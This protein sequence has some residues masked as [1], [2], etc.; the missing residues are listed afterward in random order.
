MIEGVVRGVS[1][2]SN[3][4]S[5]AVRLLSMICPRAC[6]SV[7]RPGFHLSHHTGKLVA[8]QQMR[9]VSNVTNLSKVT[10]SVKSAKSNTSVAVVNSVSYGTGVRSVDNGK[11]AKHVKRGNNA[12]I[13]KAS[14][15]QKCRKCQSGKSV[16]SVKVRARQLWPL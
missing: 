9:K 7:R 10:T 15:C 12:Q 8:G 16:K 3:L 4:L 2:V 5:R 14:T 1:R 6:P 11:S 13:V